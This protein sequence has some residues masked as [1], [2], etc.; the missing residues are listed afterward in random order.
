MCTAEG[1]KH[2]FQMP[3]L[4]SVLKGRDSFED[5]RIDGRII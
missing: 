2:I 5:L 3:S 1:S 4:M